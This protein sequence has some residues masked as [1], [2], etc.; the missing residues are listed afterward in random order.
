MEELWITKSFWLSKCSNA[1][2]EATFA[3]TVLPPL[4]VNILFKPYKCR[5]PNWICQIYNIGIIPATT[6]ILCIRPWIMIGSPQLMSIC[7]VSIWSYD[8]AEKK[9]QPILVLTNVAAF[10]WSH[11]QNLG[12]WQLACS[13]D[14][15]SI[16]GSHDG[17][18]AIFS[19]SFRQGK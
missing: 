1:E 14:N 17:D 15:C 6:C 13:C 19:A 7:L 18:F 12:I 8:G 2:D 16:L 9:M 5:L 10:L 3:K 11:D 4:R